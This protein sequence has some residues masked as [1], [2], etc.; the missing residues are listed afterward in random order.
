MHSIDLRAR[1]GP[2]PCCLRLLGKP[3]SGST[4]RMQ[5]RTGNGGPGGLLATRTTSILLDVRRFLAWGEGR[6]EWGKRSL[7]WA[8]W[9]TEPWSG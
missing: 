8:T 5:R 7:I 2:I 3:S 6:R 9:A 1:H 4:S